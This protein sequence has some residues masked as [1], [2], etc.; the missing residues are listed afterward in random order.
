MKRRNICCAHNYL[1]HHNIGTQMQNEFIFRYRGYTTISFTPPVSLHSICEISSATRIFFNFE[2]SSLKNKKFDLISKLSFSFQ[3]LR[4]CTVIF[5]T[6]LLCNASYTFHTKFCK[7]CKLCMFLS[8][9]L[10][11]FF[12][13]KFSAIMIKYELLT[14]C[15]KFVTILQILNENQ[16]SQLVQNFLSNSASKLCINAYIKQV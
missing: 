14:K 10:N 13:Y 11:P 9:Q 2:I 3:K 4:Q 5:L 1:L 16:V 6:N 7:L 12:S 15:T 8:S